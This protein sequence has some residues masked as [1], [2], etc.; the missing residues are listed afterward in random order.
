[1]SAPGNA[2]ANAINRMRRSWLRRG[3]RGREEDIARLRA[4]VSRLKQEL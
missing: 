2:D 4:Q 3:W 1:M